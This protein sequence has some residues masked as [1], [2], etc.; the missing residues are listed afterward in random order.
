MP[1]ARKCACAS[2]VA[3]IAEFFQV[4]DNGDGGG[5][6]TSRRGARGD[7]RGGFLTGLAPRVWT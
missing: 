2:H 1:D 5:G 6:D 4:G 3:K 7:G